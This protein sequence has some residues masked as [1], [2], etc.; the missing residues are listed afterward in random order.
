M[1][2]LFFINN[3]LLNQFWAEVMNT[4]KYL[5]NQMPIKRMADKTIIILEKSWIEVR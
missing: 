4:V 5:R 1:K 2:D 3:K